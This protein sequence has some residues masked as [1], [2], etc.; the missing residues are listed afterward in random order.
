ME[1]L[2]K[3]SSLFVPFISY[4]ENEVFTIW[5]NKLVLLYTKVERLVSDKH[6]SLLDTAL[7]IIE[8]EGL[9]IRPNKLD[10]NLT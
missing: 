10:R 2:V 3:N 7:S 4:E 6:S 9:P 8:N 5:P 1:R